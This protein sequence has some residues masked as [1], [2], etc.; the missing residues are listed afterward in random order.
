MEL[1][2]FL[3]WMVTSGGSGMVVFWLMEKAQF[4][5]ALRP[6]MK[7]MVSLGLAMV[8]PV[9]AWLAAVGMGYVEAPPVWQGWVERIF[10]LAAAAVVLSQG[11]HGVTKLRGRDGG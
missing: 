6:D 10:A 4:L 5:R 7:R 11:W 1:R 2:E 9:G 8:L 3:A